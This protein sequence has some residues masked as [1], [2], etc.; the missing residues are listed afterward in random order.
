MPK[1]FEYV[2]A[3]AIRKAGLEKKVSMQEMILLEIANQLK[4]IRTELEKMREERQ[5]GRNR[6][7]KRA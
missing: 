6:R 1:G 3:E 5:N 4:R 7:N 2:K